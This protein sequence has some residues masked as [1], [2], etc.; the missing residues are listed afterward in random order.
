MKNV[1]KRCEKEFEF[2]IPQKYCSPE[3][4]EKGEQAQRTRYVVCLECGYTWT[5]KSL[6]PQ[7][8]PRCKSANWDGRTPPLVSEELN[9]N[10]TVTC[11]KCG[12]EKRQG[13]AVC[14]YCKTI[15]GELGHWCGV[16][17]TQY[18]T[19]VRFLSSYKGRDEKILIIKEAFE[20]AE[21]IPRRQV[22][23]SKVS[24]QKE[25]SK[26]K[27]QKEIC[28]DEEDPKYQIGLLEEVLGMMPIPQAAEN[29]EFQEE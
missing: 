18:A 20:R 5:P 16:T 7:V 8:C 12:N 9:E 6:Y 21:L 25:I 19:I 1:C 2:V 29:A 22:E 13:V 24:E 17:L 26:V 3:C 4:K 28:I 14:P 27:E 15:R 23:I 10:E 11:M